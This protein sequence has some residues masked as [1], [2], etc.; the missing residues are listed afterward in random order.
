MNDFIKSLHKFKQYYK[1]EIFELLSSFCCCRNK[2]VY[3]N[4]DK[5]FKTLF[6]KDNYTHM[7]IDITSKKGEIRLEFS[8]SE[9][10]IELLVFL[11]Q[12]HYYE[13]RP[14]EKEHEIYQ[15]RMKYLRC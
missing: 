2:A 1:S 12:V 11:Q 13:E 7:V 5:I 6:H 9:T 4:Q 8:H 10:P 14:F 15:Q 3:I